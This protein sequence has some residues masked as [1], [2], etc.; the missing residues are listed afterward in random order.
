MVS[1]EKS[2]FYGYSNIEK[3]VVSENVKTIGMTAFKNCSKLK[4][5]ELPASLESIGESAFDNCTRLEVIVCA[6]T[7][8][9]T[10]SGNTFPSIEFTVNVPSSTAATAYREHPYW[11]QYTINVTMSSIS[12]DDDEE[13]P[14]IYQIITEE[15]E[16]EYPTVAIIGDA[17]IFGSFE[18]PET[19][20][21]TGTTYTVTV[22]APGTF[23]NN[24]LLTDISIP[25]TIIAIGESAFAGCSNLKS[26]TVNIDTP[27]DLT[28]ESD[29]RDIM[30]TSGGSSIF[31]G[32]DLETCILYVPDGST[33][34]YK[35]ADVWK[36]FKNIRPISSAG[37]NGVLADDGK[38]YDVYNLQGVKV[39]V[40]TRTLKGLPSGIYIVNGKK[41]NVK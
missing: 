40:N 19:I 33:E 30:K 12:D 39:R 23:E 2:A 3:L 16:E 38:S 14:G 31:E 8:P 5:V 18:L 9:A 1:I 37:M 29:I 15:G 17:G 25:S 6:G 28:A 32:V 10:I 22:I 35:A 26:I 24:V 11:G 20:D 41:I 4:S 36:E 21:Y 7:V 27:L 13:R 34:L